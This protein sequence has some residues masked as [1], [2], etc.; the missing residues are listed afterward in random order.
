MQTV[1]LSHVIIEY[2]QLGDILVRAIYKRK[3]SNF[4]TYLS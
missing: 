3:K 4:S 2:M 1:M